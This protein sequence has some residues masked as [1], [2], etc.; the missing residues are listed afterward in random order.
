MNSTTVRVR[1]CT[2]IILLLLFAIPVMADQTFI[3][4][5]PGTLQ[6]VL[7]AYSKAT[8]TKTVY[9]NELIEGKNSPGAQNASPGEA[10]QQILQGTG[11]TF[12]MADNNTAVLK[13]K[14]A[15]EKQSVTGQ[16]ENK[17]KESTIQQARREMN[18]EGLTVTAQKMEENIQDV[19]TSITVFDEFALEEKRIKS[20]K[21][22][23]AYTPNL[24]LVE[25]AAPG[26]LLP[27]IRGMRT[28]EGSTVGPVGMY[29]DGI[30]MLGTG[31]FDAILTDIE[32]IEVLKGPQ[33]TLYGRGTEAGV[34]NIITRKPDNEIKGKIQA[35]FG[36]DAKREYNLS[37]SGPIVK[38]KFFIGV[39]GRHYEKDGFIENTYLGGYTDDRENNF[40]KIDLRYTP[41]DALDIFLISSK[42]K[43]KDGGASTSKNG[44]NRQNANNEEAIEPETV[45]HALKVEYDF[46]NYKIESIST[47]KKYKTIWKR[48]Y[49][50]TP[51]ASLHTVFGDGNTQKN[52]AQEFRLS[53]D[54]NQLKWLIGVNADKEESNADYDVITNNISANTKNA[55]EGDSYGVFVHADYAL[56]DNL[57]LIGGLR[58]DKNNYEFKDQTLN[59]D[60]SFSE[61]SP[62]IGIKY[63]LNQNSL[64][65]STVSKGY[66]PGGFYKWAPD[67]Y[68][69][70]YD[71]E[72]LWSYEIGSK[73]S[74]L[75]GKIIVN[76]AIYYMAIDD[77]Q[78]TIATGDTYKTYKTNAA[79]ATSKGLEFD[80]SYKV[81]DTLSVFAGFGYNDTKFDN[82]QD[83]KGNYSGNTNLYA[84]EYNYNTGIRYRHRS[85]YYA[86]VAIN[87]YGDMY[88]NK[89][90]T[91]KREAF[92]LVDTKIG[93]ESEHYGFANLKLTPLRAK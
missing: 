77:M 8:G 70:I 52:I 59:L 2:T 23:A 15:T 84:P 1:F 64:L 61:V 42:L 37:I 12:Q 71:K 54:R 21:D 35:E 20:V 82:Y 29:I 27:T 25:A 9:L 85:G 44:S 65:Y 48:D 26:V 66:R 89:E 22:I 24:M 36:S 78:V 49:D 34:I 10:L 51:E 28:D 83:A 45:L 91:L 50:F 6:E 79:E 31:G 62:K 68:S 17:T 47:Y 81:T 86:R 43:H 16:Q 13:E 76:T 57:S 46:D 55:I 39:S 30:P 75:N 74:F 87:G 32:R 67:G 80:L 40:G 92:H 14:K 93:Y 18:L 58:Y 19:P 38:D 3:T 4:I 90:N 7:D 69:K 88:L 73:N 72:T 5:K 41:T 63:N 53:G 56:N 60:A 33:G 11:L